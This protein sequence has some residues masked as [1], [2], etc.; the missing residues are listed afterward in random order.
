MDKTV[1][2][3]ITTHNRIDDLDRTLRKL[4]LLVPTP[5]EIIVTAD[6]CDDG[7]IDLVA[8]KFPGVHLVV[9]ETNKGSVASRDYMLRLASSDLVLSLDDD[10]YPL[11]VDC[12]DKIREVFNQNPFAGLIHFP[13]ISNEFPETLGGIEAKTATQTSSYSNAGACYRRSVYLECPGFV[14][15]FFHAYEEP[16]YALQLLSAGF[17]V[18]L[19]SSI[20]IRHVY[21]TTERSEIRTHHRHARNELLSVLMRCPLPLALLMIPY[22]IA[23]QFLYA[24]KRGFSWVLREPVWWW[25]TI[26]TAGSVF[27]KRDPVKARVYW[28]WLRLSR[29]P[30]EVVQ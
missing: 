18:I 1:G 13:Q 29:T 7:T 12:I 9:N 3:M 27:G 10:S 15:E 5:E 28:A 11:D 19:D 2:V 21:S 6:G 16:D 24:L 30:R 23:S 8:K 20:T 26:K 22:R 4:M 25:S 14:S 17:Q